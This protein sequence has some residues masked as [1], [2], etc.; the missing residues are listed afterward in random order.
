MRVEKNNI[1]RKVF[2]LKDFR[3]VDYASSPLE[4]KPYRATDMANLL[5]RDG[6]LQKRYGFKQVYK[7]DGVNVEREI[8]VRRPSSGNYFLIQESGWPVK[9]H[10]MKEENGSSHIFANG[11][12]IVV[13]GLQ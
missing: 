8:T 3:G 4:V 5:L 1:D 6:Q 11:F 13:D 10:V 7:V 12:M 9:T 2:S